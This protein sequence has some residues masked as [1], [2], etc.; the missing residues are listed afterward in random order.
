MSGFAN[1]E[2]SVVVKALIE[3]IQKNKDYLSEV[4][5]AIG[6]G[7]HGV[8]MEK[9][10]SLCLDRV[11]WANTTFAEA[12]R[13]LSRILMM[14]IGGSMGPIYGT[15]FGEMAKVAKDKEHLS[16]ADFSQML[17][18]A[19]AGIGGLGGAKVGDK[20]LLD[21]L[22]PATKAF[23][24]SIAAENDFAAAL[25]AM[26]EAAKKGWESTKDMVAKVGRASRLGERSRGVYD[27][28]ATSCYLLLTALADSVRPLLK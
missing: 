28:G 8:N 9:G 21:A 12:M 27:A 6:D 4:D 5:G 19:V 23:D 22:V 14:E 1:K 7:D 25:T 26:S 24:D 10:F 17:N 2:G 18:A 20:T 16:S 15:L 13:T 3:T 11:D